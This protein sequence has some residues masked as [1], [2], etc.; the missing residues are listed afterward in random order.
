MTAQV[1]DIAQAMA[2]IT[3]NTKIHSNTTFNLPGPVTFNHAEM[4]NFIS[5][6]T[7]R[8][9]SGAPEVPKGFAVFLS[10]RSQLIWWPSVSPDEIERRFIDAGMV[11]AAHDRAALGGNPIEFEQIAPALLRSY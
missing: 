3:Q 11:D 6:F 2:N 8:P 1:Q 5:L 7:F 4:Q 9:V 10:K